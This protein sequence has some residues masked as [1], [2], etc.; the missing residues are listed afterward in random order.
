MSDIEKTYRACVGIALFN[1]NGDVF[2]GERTD[3]PGAWQMPQGGIDSG[4]EPLDAGYREL[5]EET[6]VRK[7][8]VEL[9]ELSPIVTQ[10]TFPKDIKGHPIYNS[11]LGQRQNWV[12]FRFKGDDSDVDIFAHDEKEFS[13]W[14]WTPL[15]SIVDTIVEFKKETYSQVIEMFQK[16]S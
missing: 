2:V 14:R 3:T 8:Q 12:A 1:S 6:G 7:D 9:L 16:Y 5:Y 4:E 10:Y 15:P 13:Q 11:H